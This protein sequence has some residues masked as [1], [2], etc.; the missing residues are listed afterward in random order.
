MEARDTCVVLRSEG[1]H[2]AVHASFCPTRKSQSQSRHWLAFRSLGK[3]DASVYFCQTRICGI[4]IRSISRILPSCL[5]G[6]YKE[7]WRL[8]TRHNNRP[9]PSQ[10]FSVSNRFEGDS[11]TATSFC[12]RTIFLPWKLIKFCWYEYFRSDYSRRVHPLRA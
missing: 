2:C 5:I 3:G 1:H 8:G 4:C 6:K 12:K 9:N 11:A 7:A 10:S